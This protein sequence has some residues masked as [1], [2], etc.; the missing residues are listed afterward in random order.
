MQQSLR[1]WLWMGLGLG[2]AILPLPVVAA[3][4]ALVQLTP[5]R[6][7]PLA[8]HLQVY[9]TVEFSPEGGRT[10]TLPA[11][12]EITQILVANGQRIQRG[13]LLVRVRSTANDQLQIQQAQIGVHFAR[14]DLDRLLGLRHQQLATN[15]EVAGA[16]QNL[17]KAQAILQD[18]QTRLQTL[19]GGAVRA[20]INGVV[21]S[22]SVHQGDLVPAGQPLLRLSPDRAL[23]IV[24]GVE[25]EDL[26]RVKVGDTVEI[27]PLAGTQGRMYGKI[28][29]IYWQVDPKTRLAQVVVPI[30]A[31]KSLLPGSMVRARII[32]NR[33]NSL[34]IPDSAVLQ[35]DGRS[36][37]FVDVQGKAQRRWIETGWRNGDWIAVRKGVQAGEA[38]VSLG[39]Y[40]LQDGMALRV[41]DKS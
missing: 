19:Q 26:A 5:A 35:Q 9:G 36:Y 22:V 31:S 11:E 40:E 14:Q 6:V 10:L 8:E 4:S 12:S 3:V 2:L 13:Q 27:R 30:A 34:V 7:M 32:L 21:E 1:R 33:Q 25:P 17:A 18:L 23:R 37:C 16:Q 29:Q 38:V 39:N 20:P 41:A 15:A 28:Q 24:L